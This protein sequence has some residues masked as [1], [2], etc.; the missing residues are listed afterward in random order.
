M[1]CQVS[2]HYTGAL[3]AS[4]A[5]RT[6]LRAFLLASPITILG[7]AWFAY[8]SLTCGDFTS[9]AIWL[10]ALGGYFAVRY[11][12]AMRQAGSYVKKWGESEIVYRLTDDILHISAPH[13]QADYPW[14]VFDRVLRFKRF[15]LLFFSR[16]QFLIMPADMTEGGAGEFVIA[17]VRENGGKV[18]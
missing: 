7:T 3:M 10:L 1:N 4:V 13:G 8:V 2:I 5:R 18:R 11:V 17:K 15:W 6:L 16:T 12:L 14:R 9:I